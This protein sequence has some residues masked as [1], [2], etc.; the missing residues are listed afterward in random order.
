MAISLHSA[1]QKISPLTSRIAS[2]ASANAGLL[3]MVVVVV[4]AGVLIFYLVILPPGLSVY[5]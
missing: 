1:L 5:P 2:V 4:A 3:A